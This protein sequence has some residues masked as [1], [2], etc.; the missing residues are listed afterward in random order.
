MEPYISFI[1][2]GRNDNYGEDFN[3]RLENHINQLASLIDQYKLHCEYIMVNYNPLEDQP[4]L[5]EKIKW[6]DTKFCTIRIITVP[7]SVHET[8]ENEDI[9][10][11]VPLYEYIAKNVGIR[12]A[13]GEY[14]C[15]LNS[16]I[17]FSPQI[18][19]FIAKRK[20]KVDMYYRCDR[21]DFNRVEIDSK[22]LPK[23]L[24]NIL[25]KHSFKAFLKGSNTNI[26][27]ANYFQFRF[28]L[29]KIKSRIKL[30]L[31]SLTINDIYPEF[32][33]H[34]NCSGDF[35]LMH[36]VNWNKLNGNPEN[37]RIAA[38]TDSMFV[39]MAAMSGL[40]EKVFRW[41]V[42]HQDHERRFICDGDTIE[43]RV[44]EMH[45]TYLKYARKMLL[46][47]A[48]IIHNDDDWGLSEYQFDEEI[49]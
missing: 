34:C 48:P 47:R 7:K 8:L 4:S 5:S 42:Y 35:M 16:D 32:H 18:I 9:R 45:Q 1:A 12:R 33:Y 28:I 38:H 10:D 26:N 49:K 39:I 46:E 14:I 15:A 11:T 37:T 40:K 31:F 24:I 2:A 44:E 17:M 22:N 36:K 3:Y 25:Q 13:K 20:L 41:P 19:Q 23:T 21:I 6:P 30:K 27:F 43:P 29:L